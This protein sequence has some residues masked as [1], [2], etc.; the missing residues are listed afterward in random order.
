MSTACRDRIPR[1]LR[2][3]AHEKMFAVSRR[4]AVMP[5]PGG[6][7]IPGR[8]PGTVGR[9]DRKGDRGDLNGDRETGD[10]AVSYRESMMS[11]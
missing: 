9:R 6:P 8:T 5:L 11:A 7:V 2:V 3:A 1:D 10:Q 4:P